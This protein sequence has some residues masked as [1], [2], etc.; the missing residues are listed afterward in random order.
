MKLEDNCFLNLENKNGSLAF[1]H[2]SCTE[3]KNKFIFLK[4]LENLEKLKLMAWAKVM[5]LKVLHIIKC[6]R[7]WVFQKKFI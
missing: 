5:D 1:L 7:K 3:W 2:A 4:F 6:P